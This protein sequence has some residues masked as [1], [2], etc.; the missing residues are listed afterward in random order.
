[1]VY[2]ETRITD[3]YGT[4][5]YTDCLRGF[6]DRNISEVY[7][8]VFLFLLPATKLFDELHYCITNCSQITQGRIRGGV[9]R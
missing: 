2:E 9:E 4:T 5:E 6:R 1:M 7:K 8:T 3:D